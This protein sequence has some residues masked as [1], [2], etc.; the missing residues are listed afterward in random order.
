MVTIEEIKGKMPI[1]E[2]TAKVISK[3]IIGNYGKNGEDHFISIYLSDGTGDIKLALFG[4]NVKKS[5][6]LEV[7][8]FWL[9]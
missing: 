7:S 2:I 3:S 5:D 6:Q 4:D 8:L 1:L 9:S